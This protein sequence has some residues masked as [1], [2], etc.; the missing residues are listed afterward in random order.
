MEQQV[1]AE[2]PMKQ[3]QEGIQ[4]S[5]EQQGTADDQMKQQQEGTQQSMEQQGTADDQMKQQQEGT[6]QSVEQ[7]GTADDQMKQQ[8]EGTQQS[9]E[10]QGTADDQM[11]QQKEGIQQSVEQQGTADDQMKQQQ[12][13]TQQSV[14]QQGTADDQ[15]K[16]QQEGT[17]QSVEQQG[18]ADDQM[19]QQQEGIQQ[20]VEQQ[21]TA[22]DQMKQQQEGTQQ[23]VEQQGTADDQMKQQ[24][25]GIQQSV[26]Q[27]G[28]AD[29]QMK[30]QQEGIQQSVEQ[31]GTAEEQ[32]KQQR[33]GTQQS[34]EQQ[35]TA[36]E[37]MKQQREGTQQSVEQQELKDKKRV[38]KSSAEQHLEQATQE[39][40]RQQRVKEPIEEQHEQ[41]QDEIYNEE[42]IERATEIQD[43][44]KHLGLQ[45][46]FPS[47]ISFHEIIKIYSPITE[48]SQSHSDKEEDRHDR[49]LSVSTRRAWRLL[50]GLMA[51]RASFSENSEDQDAEQSQETELHPTDILLACFLCSDKELQQI[52]CQRL[53]TCKIAFPFVYPGSDGQLIRNL[54]SMRD[55]V[56]EYR[57]END[58]HVEANLVSEGHSLFTICF[59]RVGELKLSKSKIVNGLLSSSGHDSFIHRDCADGDIDRRISNGVVEATISLPTGNRKKEL[60][61]PA[62]VLNLRGDLA[63]C[64]QQMQFISEVSQ[65]SVV[66]VEFE[67]L[68]EP[69]SLDVIEM[70][71]KTTNVVLVVCKQKAT[72]NLSN[73]TSQ[74]LQKVVSS[75]VDTFKAKRR[76]NQADLLSDIRTSINQLM[77]IELLQ[78][79]T[80]STPMAA[81]ILMDEDEPV[82]ELKKQAELAFKFINDTEISQFKQ[83]FL[84]LQDIWREYSQLHKEENSSK[85]YQ[86][87]LEQLQSQKAKLREKQF[88][89]C[90]QMSE[91]VKIFIE[92][93]QNISQNSKSSTGLESRLFLQWMRIFFDQTSRKHLPLISKKRNE[94]R[95][96]LQEAEGRSDKTKVDEIKKLVQQVEHKIVNSSVGLE[97]VFREIGQMFEAVKENSS[98]VSQGL[99]DVAQRLPTMFAQLLLWGIPLEILDGDASNIAT[100]WVTAVLKACQDMVGQKR[101]FVISVLGLQSS[102]K[103]TLL[104]TMFGL[105]FPV[106]AGRCTRGAFLQLVTVDASSDLP[107]DYVAVIDTEGLRAPELA[108]EKHQHDNELATLVIGLGDVTLINIKGENTAEMKDI[109]QIAIHAFIRMKMAN[110]MRDLH[111]KCIFVHQ[112]V[113]AVGAKEKMSDATFKMEQSLDEITKEAAEGEGLSNITRFSQILEF[114]RDTDIYY[115]PDLW[116]GDPPMAPVNPGYSFKVQEV[117][118]SLLKPQN[119]QMKSFLS[120]N[121]FSL[122]VNDMWKAIMSEDFVFSFKNSIEMKAYNQMEAAYFEL[123]NQMESEMKDWLHKTAT[124]EVKKCQSSQQVQ[125]TQRNLQRQLRTLSDS[126]VSEAVRKLDNFFKENQYSEYTIQWKEKKMN[127]IRNSADDKQNDIKKKIDGLCRVQQL[128]ASQKESQ[129]EWRKMII[130]NAK[131]LA[132]TLKPDENEQTLKDKF[133]SMWST[134]TQD[135]PQHQDETVTSVENIVIELLRKKY[136]KEYETMNFYVECFPFTAK[137]SSV[138]LTG[139]EVFK[140]IE[141][142]EILNTEQHNFAKDKKKR[143]ASKTTDKSES[144]RKTEP[145][146]VELDFS[147]LEKCANFFGLSSKKEKEA[148]AAQKVARTCQDAIDLVKVE[149]EQLTNQNR[150]FDSTDATRIIETVCRVLQG[151]AVALRSEG[152]STTTALE[153]KL[154]VMSLS[155]AYPTFEAVDKKFREDHSVKSELQKMKQQ[156]FNMFKN[157][158]K[159]QKAAKIAADFC[160]DHVAKLTKEAIARQI[161]DKLRPHILKEIGNTKYYLIVKMLSDMANREDFGGILHYVKDSYSAA[162]KWLLPVVNKMTFHDKKELGGESVTFYSHVIEVELMHPISKCVKE[163]AVDAKKSDTSLKSWIEK[164]CGSVQKELPITQDDLAPMLEY[165]IQKVDDVVEFLTKG[166]AEVEKQLMGEYRQMKANDID[167]QGD[168]CSGLLSDMWGCKEQCPFCNEPCSKTS[169]DSDHHCIQHRPQAVNGVRELGTCEATFGTCEYYVSSDYGFLNF[170]GKS[171]QYKEYRKYFSDWTINPD[172][173]NTGSKFW[174][175]FCWR[176]EDEI[177]SRHVF[178]TNRLPGQWKNVSKQD[179]IDSLRL[180]LN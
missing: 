144:E 90:T 124:V 109:L 104:N 87:G 12:E 19:K 86:K 100:S 34:V 50:H 44:V 1:P 115:M 76:K 96:Q 29:D 83:K 16:Q 121:D 17:Q 81:N 150:W 46:V 158:V 172:A 102:G 106:S 64:E 9:V 39:A 159:Q 113:P 37:Q 69:S 125:E 139:E 47:K 68:Q 170:H 77:S 127:S 120:F 51:N 161:T 91:F 21:G 36:E 8:Q 42:Q 25:E 152:I 74:R 92:L 118:N 11:N 31:Q 154:V 66:F 57:D 99:A 10:Q 131:Q 72:Q 27:Q 142:S 163:A 175:W 168:L 6:Q 2:N 45:D 71:S 7:Q 98:S 140:K 111:R 48:A 43:V 84:P 49:Q 151:S 176:F 153:V 82:L 22:D 78:K 67:S 128:Q 171:G 38:N 133:E 73:V 164:F 141:V 126:Q 180:L 160:R 65:I 103:S 107:F 165:D 136:Q 105:K 137:G 178:K 3:Q 88:Q 54:W 135:L 123:I 143:G 59:A 41:E 134:G 52:L 63:Y 162:Q 108:L 177:K 166:I 80:C 97:N 32:M 53:F 110:K 132:E 75:T 20:S 130:T 148:A 15:M 70:L 179:A 101:I 33:E 85:Q 5:V 30:Q 149:V 156:V 58:K 167:C 60:S 112:N 145:R 18:T 23:S 174:M 95:T 119:A 40:R 26:E 157:M 28:T 13:G 24:Q 117:K 155:F 62:L 14:E 129:T 122:R 94:L 114:N 147:A 4:Q 79:D 138:T 56:V 169:A 55:I 116:H 89:C 93:L 61:R 35:G 173:S 146:L